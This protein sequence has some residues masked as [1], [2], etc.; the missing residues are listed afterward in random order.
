MSLEP[1]VVAALNK[2][3]DLNYRMSDFKDK[4]K[5]VKS[6]K[7]SEHI[8]T[9]GSYAFLIASNYVSDSDK[10]E[11]I[12]ALDEVKEQIKV[13]AEFPTD[14]KN[15]STEQFQ[16]DEFK[17]KE[18]VSAENEKTFFA[19]IRSVI[20]FVISVSTTTALIW[21]FFVW[22]ISVT[23]HTYY[24]RRIYQIVDRNIHP[25]KDNACNYLYNDIDNLDEDLSKLMEITKR[26]HKD[27]QTGGIT[28][29]H[30]AFIVRN[31]DTA[32]KKLED[33]LYRRL[34]MLF[35]DGNSISSDLLEKFFLSGF[36]NS[37]QYFAMKNS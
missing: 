19:M 20:L 9:L 1:S 26:L 32:K 29:T 14:A 5:D 8:S 16:L 10:W 21:S 3:Y 13:I 18:S 7:K 31:L 37:E 34:K 25:I 23:K 28:E 4:Y 36:I 24:F 6:F 11:L 12:Q 27:Y 30:Y 17:F 22:V 15:E 2:D 35:E 33:D